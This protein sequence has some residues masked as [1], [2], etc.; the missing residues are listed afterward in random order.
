L[1]YVAQHTLT[2]CANFIFT[3][4]HADAVFVEGDDRRYWVHE[5]M[6]PLG[7]GIGPK[8]EKWSL[9]PEGA[10][11]LRYFFENYDLEGFGPT[12]HAPTTQAKL[13][14]IDAGRSELD[15]WA[16]DAFAS[17]EGI[18]VAGTVDNVPDLWSL[19]DLAAVYEHTHNKTPSHKAL[20]KSLERAGMLKTPRAVTKR[21][22]INLYAVKNIHHWRRAEPTEIGSA[23]DK[24]L[25][26]KKF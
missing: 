1:K 16:C 13:D 24:T 9:T 26:A 2:D 20:A 11:A 10:G 17:P 25:N 3:S 21:G 4:N 7:P 6:T 12:D 15:G 8:M 5:V 19:P 22:R 14:M 18:L 23:Y